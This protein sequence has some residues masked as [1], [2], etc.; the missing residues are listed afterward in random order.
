MAI[1]PLYL[2]GMRPIW[3]AGHPKGILSNI[4]HLHDFFSLPQ[5]HDNTIRPIQRHNKAAPT[6]Q[7]G[8]PHATL[9]DNTTTGRPQAGGL[10]ALLRPASRFERTHINP[11]NQNRTAGGLSEQEQKAPSVRQY[12]PSCVSEEGRLLPPPREPQQHLY[13]ELH[14]ALAAR[15]PQ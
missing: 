8:P 15:L 2:P 6:H 13:Q 9:V 14:D 4:L 3:R 1:S 10:E 12:R 11:A 7:P 5:N